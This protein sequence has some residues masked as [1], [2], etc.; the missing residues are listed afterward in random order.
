MEGQPMNRV[1]FRLLVLFLALSLLALFENAMADDAAD[2]GK[3]RS[4]ALTL[5]LAGTVVDAAGQPGVFSGT[6]TINRFASLNHEIV[7]VGIVRGTVTT[8]SGQVTGLGTV[9]LPVT[10][11]FRSAGLA[12]PPAAEPRLV[13]VS[14]TTDTSGRFILAQAQSCGILH[15]SVGGNA[16][17]LLGFTVNLSPITLDISGDSAGPLGSLVCQIVALLGTAANV[18]GV[19]NNLLGLLTGLVGGLTG[20]VG[21]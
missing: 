16:V 3:V 13:P 19:L 12:I 15:L 21:G 7:A 6:V 8:A 4:G 1:Q 2:R 10:T 14:W 9:V 18:V 17:N 5:P 11:G 20:G